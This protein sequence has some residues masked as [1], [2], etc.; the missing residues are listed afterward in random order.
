MA[1]EGCCA[2]QG[3]CFECCLFCLVTKEEGNGRSA[4]KFGIVG[5]SD[6]EGPSRTCQRS[7]AFV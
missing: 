1:S 4:I 6:D 2:R 3:S 7:R 5:N